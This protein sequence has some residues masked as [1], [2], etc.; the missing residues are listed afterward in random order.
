MGGRLGWG[1][2]ACS[3]GGEGVGADVHAAS[4]C[5]G[6]AVLSPGLGQGLH[7]DRQVDPGNPWQQPAWAVHFERP[8]AGRGA[9]A[10]L[11]PG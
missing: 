6:Q 7:V 10:G 5:S 1:E 9:D 8:A 3:A 4:E 11:P 2:G